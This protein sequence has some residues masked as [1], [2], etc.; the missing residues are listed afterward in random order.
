MITSRDTQREKK[1]DMVA[2]ACDPTGEA[3]AGGLQVQSQSKVH[4]KTQLFCFARPPF[5]PGSIQLTVAL[6]LTVLR[7]ESM[8]RS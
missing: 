6:H 5:P 1:S 3:E 2:I 4:S 8:P 7:V